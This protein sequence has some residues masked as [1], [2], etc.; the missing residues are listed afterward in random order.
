MN[1]SQCFFF[2]I[3]GLIS[4]SSALEPVDITRS[5]RKIQ[6]DGFLMDWLEKNRQSWNGSLVWSWDAINTEEGVAGYLHAE[7]AALCTTWTLGADAG[8][9]VREITPPP[10]AGS[11]GPFY[12]VNQARNGN[13]MSLTVEWLFPWDSIAA[14]SSG[15]YRIAIAGKDFCGDRQ[16]TILLAGKARISTSGPLPKRFG[17]R[18]VIIIAL[19]VVFVA[20]QMSIRRQR[21]RRGS[22][23]RSA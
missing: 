16:D 1:V 5:G 17:M 20:L 19:L 7:D 12:R 14:D 22:P 6:L 9:G 21:R 2:L 4:L 13:R 18:L 15:N 10:A 8:R 3:A 23:R 11:E